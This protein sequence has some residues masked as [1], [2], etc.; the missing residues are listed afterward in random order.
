MVRPRSTWNTSFASS[1]SAFAAPRLL[2]GA[3]TV[4]YTGFRL[5]VTGSVALTVSRQAPALNRL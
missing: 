4:A 3:W 5:P 1:L 2:F